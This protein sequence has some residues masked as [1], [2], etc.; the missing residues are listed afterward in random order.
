MK[1]GRNSTGQNHYDHHHTTSSTFPVY[2]HCPNKNLNLSL[3]TK[4]V[5]VGADARVFVQFLGQTYLNK[6]RTYSV[7]SATAVI[8]LVFNARVQ[9]FLGAVFFG[10][11]ILPQVEALT[12]NGN[13]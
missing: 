13:H 6:S 11:R 12:V 5:T 10:V 9:I 3:K 1:R 8:D 7:A 4:P 2:V